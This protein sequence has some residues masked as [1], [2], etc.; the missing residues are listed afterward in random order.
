MDLMTD[1]TSHSHLFADAKIPVRAVIGPGSQRLGGAFAAQPSKNYTT[2][3][4]LAAALAEG[5]SEVHP[6]ASSEDS[7]ALQSCLHSLGAAVCTRGGRSSV[8]GFGNHPTLKSGEPINVGNAGAVLRMLLG[9]GA[10]LPRVMFVTDCS[11]SLGKRPNGDLLDALRQMG[12]ESESLN[13]CLPITLRGGSLRGG[14]VEISGARSS[15]FLSSLL[16]LSPLVGKP[17][18]IV[19][20]D[21]LVSKAPVRQTLEVMANAG[22]EVQA[23]EDL[24]HFEIRPQSYRAGS[25]D[26]NGDWPGSAAILSAA[27]VTGSTINAHGLLNDNQG[28]KRALDVLRQMGAT[29]NGGFPNFTLTGGE[30]NGVEFD[31]DLATDAVLAL[32]GAAA[33]ATGRTRFYNVANLRIKECDRISEPITELRKIGVK[34]WEGK[35]IGDPDPD[36]IIVEGNSGGY[37]GGIEVDGRGDHRVIMLLAIVGLRCKRGLVINGAHHVTKSYPAFFQHLGQLGAQ[38]RLERV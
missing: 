27:A 24:M 12:C 4:L 6:V 7:A 23:A 18:E 31:G 26:V 22:V 5:R 30:L 20:K 36:A 19:V 8:T 37:E 14:R 3:C 34:C 35:E 25:F 17:M 11:E 32:V 2:R 29:I 38:V 13:G 15:Q 10:L 16:F 21:T 28:E 1:N 33:L 9:V